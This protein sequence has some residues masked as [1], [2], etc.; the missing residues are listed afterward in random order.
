MNETTEVPLSRCEREGAHKTNPK[1]PKLPPPASYT[2]NVRTGNSVKPTRLC[3]ACILD[4][5]AKCGKFNEDPEHKP[6]V[7]LRLGNGQPLPVCW[8]CERSANGKAAQK[9]MTAPPRS[10][11]ALPARPDHQEQLAALRALLPGVCRWTEVTQKER[12]CVVEI[13]A[14]HRAPYDAFAAVLTR[15]LSTGPSPSYGEPMGEI[16]ARPLNPNAFLRSDYSYFV[17]SGGE[18]PPLGHPWWRDLELAVPRT[19]FEPP[20]AQEGWPVGGLAGPATVCER[21]TGDEVSGC[22]CGMTQTAEPVTVRVWITAE[23]WD[24]KLN[25]NGRDMY[26]FPDV[27]TE[28]SW[29]RREGFVTVVADARTLERLRTMAAE[30]K[31]TLH[32]GEVPPAKTSKKSARKKGPEKPSATVRLWIRAVAWK[33]LPDDS[34][35]A[36]LGSDCGL[37]WEFNGGFVTTT[38]TKALAKDVVRWARLVNVHVYQGDEPPQVS[39]DGPPVVL[40]PETRAECERREAEYTAPSKPKLCRQQPV[41]AADELAQRGVHV[42]AVE[43]RPG[44]WTRV[45]RAKG[46]TSVAWMKRAKGEAGRVRVY[47]GRPR[48][49]WDSADE[50]AQERAA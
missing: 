37:T 45:E 47:D 40:T 31:I 16:E 3:E 35:R 46:E 36:A 24:A 25:E 13:G 21:C 10:P 48:C 50:M 7:P 39:T 2:V 1:K 14:P 19:E 5:C 17:T 12:L 29:E 26:E 49:T 4:W 9:F 27:D 43:E 8:A 41:P 32:E 33:G 11:A 34:D 42:Y 38:A 23:E 28:L 22:I 15:K 44:E 20:P 30:D 6:S 18:L